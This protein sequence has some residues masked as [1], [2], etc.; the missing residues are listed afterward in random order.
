MAQQFDQSYRYNLLVAS[1]LRVSGLNGSF[2]ICLDTIIATLNENYILLLSKLI[3][4][5][6]DDAA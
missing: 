1:G 3:D 5:N 2:D 4:E 6:F